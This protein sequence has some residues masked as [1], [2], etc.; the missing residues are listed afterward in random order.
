M[1]ILLVEIIFL[2]AACIIHLIQL[3]FVKHNYFLHILHKISVWHLPVSL[4][5]MHIFDQVVF[6]M[7]QFM[8]LSIDSTSGIINLVIV[9][10]NLIVICYVIK[11]IVKVAYLNY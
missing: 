11:N 5:L 1:E 3:K 9:I 4:F 8:F 10:V 6:C 7:G 2:I